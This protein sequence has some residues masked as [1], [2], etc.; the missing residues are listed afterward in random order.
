MRTAPVTKILD[1]VTM[2]DL[3]ELLKDAGFRAEAV[4]DAA[5]G[6][7]LRSATGGV[8]FEVRPGNVR[9][10]DAQRCVDFTYTTL[11]RCGPG[12]PG[13][14][15]NDWNTKKRFGRLHQRGD[16]VVLEQDVIIAGGV[17]RANLSASLELWNQLVNQLLLA[18]RTALSGDVGQADGA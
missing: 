15:V 17:T 4:D 1:S 7:S 14:L 13:D 2:D 6:R 11:I 3:A 5:L 10:D 9:T 12:L 16:L 18:L 8:T